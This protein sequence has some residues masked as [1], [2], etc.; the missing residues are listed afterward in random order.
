VTWYCKDHL[1]GYSGATA[2][3]G[4]ERGMKTMKSR[5]L[6]AMIAAVLG[7]VAAA[8]AGEVTWAQALM[9][10]A[11]VVVAYLAGQSYVDGQEAA[12]KGGE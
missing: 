10:C 5:K 2:P 6:W 7:S 4:K 3:R 12:A 11:G 1:P 8:L 9:A